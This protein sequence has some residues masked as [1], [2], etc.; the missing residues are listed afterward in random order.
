MPD[1]TQRDPGLQ[2]ERTGLA[3]SRTGLLALL[4]ASLS[5]RVGF[6]VTDVARMLTALLLAGL[7]V[8]AVRRDHQR[9]RYV[10]G[11][12]VVTRTSRMYI[13][14]TSAIVVIASASH[15]ALLVARYLRAPL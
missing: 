3:W 14:A 12:E 9:A 8:A 15:A 1:Q 2:P 5:V 4:A 10:A 11:E 7:A 6:S 13:F